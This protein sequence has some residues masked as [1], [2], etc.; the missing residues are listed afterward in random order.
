MEVTPACYAHLVKSLSALANGKLAVVMEVPNLLTTTS[1]F[2]I[3]GLCFL[4]NAISNQG[5]Y[6]LRSLA[7]GAALTL[8]ALLGY[9]T[10]PL[11]AMVP[12]CD[13]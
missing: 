10:P 5:G 3:V 1:V 9:P 12:P 8:R 13:V 2:I 7:E 11:P 6:C 4:N